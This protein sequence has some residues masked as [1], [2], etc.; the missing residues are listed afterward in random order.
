MTSLP[1]PFT[2]RTRSNPSVNTSKNSISKILNQRIVIYE[3]YYYFIKY[4]NST[5]WPSSGSGY[6]GRWWQ[7][8]DNQLSFMW[9]LDDD[10]VELDGC[11][12]PPNVFRIGLCLQSILLLIAHSFHRFLVISSGPIRRCWAG[13]R[14]LNRHGWDGTA[15][16]SWWFH[17][18]FF[19]SRIGFFRVC[20]PFGFLE[21]HLCDVC[22][23]PAA[24]RL[25]VL[26]QHS[27]N[28]WMVKI[29]Y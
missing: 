4:C 16:R 24:H 21:T 29:C 2:M 6:F 12:H 23:R 28:L 1:H 15:S 11:V 7:V 3:W 18:D 22:T 19:Q 14:S 5:V 9:P 27:L 10:F 13:W 26:I 20:I 8:E 17:F 25:P